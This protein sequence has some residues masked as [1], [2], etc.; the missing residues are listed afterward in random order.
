M[1][2]PTIILSIL[3]VLWAQGC[4][5]KQEQDSQSSMKCGAGKCGANMFDS[6]SALG[7]KK[8]NILSQLAEDDDR[9]S[10]VINANTTKTLYNCVRD[11]KTGKLTLEYSEQPRKAV[12]KC[13]S[14]KCGDGK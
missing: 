10:C 13:E 8:A 3:M 9:R 14:G 7:R 11:P 5:E 6:G 12:M 2:L 4:G 1:N